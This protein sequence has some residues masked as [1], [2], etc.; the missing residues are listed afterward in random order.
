V[1]EGAGAG[2]ILGTK[3][4]SAC[5]ISLYRETAGTDAAKGWR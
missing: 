1:I 2:S 4:V 5:C 3:D